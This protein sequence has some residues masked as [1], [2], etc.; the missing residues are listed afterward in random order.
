MKNIDWT[1]KEMWQ[2]SGNGMPYS[3]WVEFVN[4]I[5]ED[6]RDKLL[7]VLINY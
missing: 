1:S 4:Y 6:R 3:A 2:K 7:L 5:P